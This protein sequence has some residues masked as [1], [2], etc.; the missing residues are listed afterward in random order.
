VFVIETNLKFCKKLDLIW[1][2]TSKT[3]RLTEVSY[4]LF[5]TQKIFKLLP[6]QIRAL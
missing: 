6:N 4:A 5:Y 1:K 2:E 3:L